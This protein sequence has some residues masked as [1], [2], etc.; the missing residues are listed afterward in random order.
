MIE[1]Y[2]E[3]DE[4]DCGD[5]VRREGRIDRR[6]LPSIPSAAAGN[7]EGACLSPVTARFMGVTLAVDVA[8]LGAGDLPRRA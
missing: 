2:D 6:V 8:T 4:T 1:E 5:I 3:I 7:A